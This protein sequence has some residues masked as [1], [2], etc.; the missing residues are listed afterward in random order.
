LAGTGAVTTGVVAGSLLGGPAAEAADATRSEAVPFFG[1]HQAGIVTPQQASLVFAAYDMVTDDRSA[2]AALLATWTEASTRL[3]AGVPLG[4]GSS[5]LAPPPDTGEAL[6][7]GPSRLTLTVGFGP[8]LFDDRFGLRHLRPAALAELPAFALDAL[9]PA[10]S[11]GDLCVQACADDPQVAFHAVR[12]LTRLA[13]GAATLRYYQVGFGM[14]PPGG[15]APGGGAQTPRNLLGFHDGTGNRSVLE[16]GGP[17]RHVW[18]GPGTA[19]RWMEGGTYL[20]ARRIRIFLEAWAGTSLGDQEATVGRQ[21]VSGAP[22]G[23]VH[24]Y[25]RLDL[26]ALGPGGVPTIPTSAHVRQASATLNGGAQILRRSFNFADGLDPLTGELDAGLYFIC[27]QRDP[28]QF[29]AI[30]RRLSA[31]DALTGGYL[32]HTSSAVFACPPGLAPGEHWGQPL[33]LD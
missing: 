33:G 4:G 23:G 25:D 8:G 20:V 24:Q 13:L 29:V 9:D 10:R 26:D 15:T 30:Q 7:L 19:P 12:N 18:V 32:L 31:A 17:E 21:K 11:G 3:V 28:R 16:P 5:P 22:L 6:G 27:F 14:A 2:L 1:P